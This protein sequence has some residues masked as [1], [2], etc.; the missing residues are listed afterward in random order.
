M[1]MD[2][3]SPGGFSALI[4]DLGRNVRDAANSRDRKVQKSVDSDISKIRAESDRFEI[5]SV[6][7]YAVFASSVDGIFEVKPLAHG[8]RSRSVLGSR[9]Y[10]RPLRAAPRPTRTGVLVADRSTARTFI[11]FEGS[12]EEIG[13]PLEADGG[14]SNYGGFGGYSEHKVRSRADEVTT[15][16]W[17]EAGQRLLDRHLD[18]SLDS[19][20]LGGQ[21]EVIDEMREQLHPYLKSLPSSS[22]AVSPA[23]VSIARLRSEIDEQRRELR[24]RNERELV[25]KVMAAAQRGSGA[26]TGLADSLRAAN[27]QAISDLVVAGS[28][29]RPGVM[30]PECGYL[31][32]S[33]SNC[34]VC[35][36]PMHEVVDVVG[37]LID[38]TVESGGA[39]HQVVVG[40]AL[41]RDGV[42][43]LTRFDIG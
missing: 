38:A 22:F 9:P 20:L 13:R 21:G 26:V 12:I 1:Y 3:P 6:P 5:E 11:G 31:D 24:H 40:S 27:A 33:G 41:D 8:V 36:A 16:L 23:D 28:F 35:S 18:S 7:A 30:C 25:S 42:G 4:S 29:S 34:Q 32:R 19:L 14:K 37:A 17:R 10:L 2:R 15:R 39:V 43:A